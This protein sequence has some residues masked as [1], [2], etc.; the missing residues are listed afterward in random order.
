MSTGYAYDHGWE[1]ERLRLSGLE[2]A[3]DPG[4]R[5]HLTRLGVKPG[6]R[7]LEVGAG[8]GSIATWLAD[9]VA[10]HGVTVAVDLETDFLEAE[11]ARYPT[12]EVRQL[13]IM[14]DELPTGF[15]VIHARWLIE[16][17]ADKNLAI[18]RLAGALRPGG[19]LLIEEPDFVTLF[20]AA[21]PAALRRVALAAMRHLE[22][23]C[24]VEVEYGRRATHDLIAAGLTG[25]EAEGRCPIVPGG[26]PLAAHFLRYTFEKFRE[27]LLAAETVT[28]REFAEAIS[29]L[30]DPNVT[31]VG[32]MTV[33]AWGRQNASPRR[34]HVDAPPTPPV[35]GSR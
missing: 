31:V 17:L 28:E 29:A 1:V 22:S 15:D 4:T 13:D 35:P 19:V 7:C 8:G 23:T 6:I 33:A 16:W 3:L 20:G 34:R 30:E 25:V 18:Q 12:L 21:E 27:P 14:S 9:Q 24:P 26:H 2:A 5:A 10:P 11:A 32:P